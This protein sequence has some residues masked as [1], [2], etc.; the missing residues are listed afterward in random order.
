MSRAKMQMNWAEIIKRDVIDES[1]WK[2]VIDEI[3]T[4]H[5]S[6]PHS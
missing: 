4:V 5:C 1:K 2:R 3:A 6:A